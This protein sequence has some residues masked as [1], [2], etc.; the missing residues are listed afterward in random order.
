M[1]ELFNLLYCLIIPDGESNDSTE[2]PD[3]NNNSQ[4]RFGDFSHL[5]S[6]NSPS[7]IRPSAIPVPPPT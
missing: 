1:L 4:D 7:I 3:G 5:K 2:A 6:I